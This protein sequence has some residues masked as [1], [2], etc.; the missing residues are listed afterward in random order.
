MKFLL[1]RESHVPV[2]VT[3][4]YLYSSMSQSCSGGLRVTP[5]MEAI[6]AKPGYLRAFKDGGQALRESISH[7]SVALDPFQLS[8]F[9]RDVFFGCLDDIKTAFANGTAPDPAGT[10]TPFKTGYASWVILGAQRAQ[11][12]PPGSMRHLETLQ[13]LLT[14][15]VPPDSED[16]AGYTALQHATTSGYEQLALVR[17][18]LENGANVNHRNR[19]GAI[20]LL[21]AL[22]RRGISSIELLMEHGAD[23]DIADADGVTARKMYVTSGPEVNAV[24]TKWVKKRAGEE[25]AP[26]GEKH[27][28]SCGKRPKGA[29][30]LKTCGKCKVARYCSPDCQRKAWPTHKTKCTP[31]TAETTVTLKPLYHKFGRTVPTAEVIRERMGMKSDPT[32]FSK[33]QTRGSHVPKNLDGGKSLVIK[34][35]VPVALGFTDD[36]QR[37]SSADLMVYTKKRDFACA[38]RRADAP[39]DYDQLSEVVRTKTMSKVKGYFAAE[40]ESEDKLVV[41]VGEVLADQPW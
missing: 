41:K 9:T 40:L 29:A 28:D 15:G 31:F 18:L 11:A 24:M 27:C 12:G 36:F 14:N 21:S 7:E 1:R 38:I 6:I 25:A 5:A 8:P 33:G 23:I 20:S 16:I 10:E 26:R 22:M 32:A 39:A 2:I 37:R 13:F 19:Y 17:C 30:E 3:R 34:V 35:Q 4:D